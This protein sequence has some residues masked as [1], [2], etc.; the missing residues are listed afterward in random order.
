M[1]GERWEKLREEFENVWRK[2]G[3]GGREKDFRISG[4][5]WEK[6]GE[7]FENFWRKV[8]EGGEGWRSI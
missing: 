4:E 1:S 6:V 5:R 8:G 3:E 7:G 2:I